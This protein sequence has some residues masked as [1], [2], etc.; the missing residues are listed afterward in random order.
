MQIV[1][2]N[3]VELEV[4]EYEKTW[5][6]S[7]RQVAQ[8]F[9]VSQEAI[10]Q[11]RTKGATEYVEGVHFYYKNMYNDGKGGLSDTPVDLSGGAQTPQKMTFWTKKGVV[12]L[13][14]KLRETPQTI[15][16]RDWASD[17]IIQPNKPSSATD[18]FYQSALA[19]KEQEQRIAQI[20][21]ERRDDHK[22]LAKVKH[23]INRLMTNEQYMTIIAYANLKGIPAKS[24]N[25]SALGRKAK[26]LS[27][28]LGLP[29]G[30]VIDPRYGR[31]GTYAIEVLELIF[32][33]IKRVG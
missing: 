21:Q 2:F 13:G 11:Q 12:T 22:E 7:D 25:S 3:N 31:V 29:M 4:L 8:G 14:F 17:Y 33:D 26:K 15:A 18:L 9:G 28:E 10:R 16:F 27:N 1:K 30:A 24:Y 32:K 20:E 5:A 19:L 23:N 6:L